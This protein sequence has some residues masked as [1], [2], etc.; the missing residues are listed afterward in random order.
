MLTESEVC[1]KVDTWCGNND[2]KCLPSGRGFSFD[3]GY[4]ALGFAGNCGL[5]CVI[6]SSFQL[7]GRVTS[8]CAGDGI[9]RDVLVFFP[10]EGFATERIAMVALIK[11]NDNTGNGDDT[12][13]D[14][15]DDNEDIIHIFF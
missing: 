6:S 7:S 3:S 14:D 9:G 12:V 5:L 13:D 8:N 2:F 10:L 4:G 11:M 1:L 15:D